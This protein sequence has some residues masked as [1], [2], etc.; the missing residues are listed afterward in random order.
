MNYWLVKSEPSAYSWD[1]FVKQGVGV[2]DGVRNY[3]ARNNMQAMKV[4]DL[5]F[6][7]HSN[8]GLEVVGLAKVVKE[9]YQDPTTEDT[10]WV[11]VEMTAVEK[12][13]KTVTLK[14]MK[15]DERLSDLALVRQSRLSVTPVKPEEFDIIIGL[16]HE[17]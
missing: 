17:G 5:V 2:W 7:Y 6:F 1:D 10:R 4:G 16:A 9:A 15:A 14:Q 8:E 3:Q 11:V 13:P 12:F